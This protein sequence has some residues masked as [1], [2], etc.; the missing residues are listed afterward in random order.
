MVVTEIKNRD[1]IGENINLGDCRV[2]Q[3][4]YKN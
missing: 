4:G 2:F 3:V 1:N